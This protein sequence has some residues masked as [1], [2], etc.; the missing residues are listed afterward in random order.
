MLT[1]EGSELN[2]E[3]IESFKK[4]LELMDHGTLSNAAVFIEYPFIA[5]YAAGKTAGM[6]AALKI[7]QLQ[8]RK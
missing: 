8:T 3:A 7:M 2:D 4:W 5:G 1:P 6:K